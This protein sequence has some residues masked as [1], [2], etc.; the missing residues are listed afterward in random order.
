MQQ[1]LGWSGQ[2]LFIDLSTRRCRMEETARYVDFIGGRGIN[3]HLLFSHLDP[4]T[5]P[6]GEESLLILGAGPLVGTLVSSAGRLSVEYRNVITGGVGSANSGGRFGAEMKYAGFDHVVISGKAS[7]PIYLFIRD[8]EVFFRDARHLWGVDTWT[9]DNLIRDAERDPLVSTLTI[10]MAGEHMVA[11]ACIIG[12][13]GRAAGS[14]GCGAVM[15]SKNLK[16]IAVRG[17]TVAIRP[18]RPQAFM[19][20]VRRFANEKIAKSRSVSV[21]RA[22]GTVGAYLLGGQNRPHGVRNMSDDFWSDEAIAQV[23]REKFDAFMVRRQACFNCPAYCSTIYRVGDTLTEGIQANTLRA[24]GSNVDVRSPE[25]ILRCNALCNKLGLDIDQTSAA[26]AWAIEC[27][28]KGLLD[29]SDMDGKQLRF[30]DAS[31]VEDLIESIAARIGF[32]DI[33]ARGVHEASRILGRDSEQ[34]TVLVKKNSV[35]EAAMRSHRA[36]ALGVVTSTKGTGHMRGAPQQEFRGFS[37]DESSSFFGVGDIRDPMSYRNKADL[38]VWQERYKGVVDMMGI[39]VGVSMWS[40]PLLFSP[41]ELGDMLSDLTGLD[42]TSV[43][44][45]Q[46]GERLQNLERAFNMLH[47]GFGRKDDMPPARFVREPVSAGRFKG[48]KI[49]M[50]EWNRML[51]EYYVLHGWD[52]VTGWPRRETLQALDLGYVIETCERHGIALP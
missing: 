33:L 9:S 26:V 38:V 37:P 52:P 11:F 42:Y 41:D 44:L 29:A 27:F 16:A 31:C 22:S 28:E 6:L 24:F 10:G 4:S 51:T 46:A 34:L 21:K 35:M 5:D 13:R 2:I 20:R 7:S 43:A 8:G 30:G 40:D 49:D 50:E 39:C 25:G 23:A 12:D 3:Q 36:W 45:M 32:G 18:A 15:G 48:A 47:A 17:T 19:Q 14:G 1:R